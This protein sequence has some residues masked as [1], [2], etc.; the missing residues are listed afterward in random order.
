MGRFS[1]LFAEAD[2]AFN[3]AYKKEL[4]NLTGLS[5]KE[6][7]AVTP[8]TEDLRI[9]SVLV[10]VVE[11]ASKKNISKAQLANDIKELGDI[12]VK[13]AKKIPELASL[14]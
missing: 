7:D 6:I 5:K 1:E 14:L 8:G 11:Q 3:G 12:A 2:A 13:I 10:K 4:D 9:Y